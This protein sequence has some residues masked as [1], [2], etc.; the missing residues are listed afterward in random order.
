MKKVGSAQMGGG[1]V[2]ASSAR[3]AIADDL[4]VLTNGYSG[5]YVRIRPPFY[6][7]D[8]FMAISQI[9]VY[10]VIGLN[11]ATNASVYATSSID[12]T[13]PAI[14][15]VDGTTT[16]RDVPNVW[17][18]ATPNRQRE[19]IELD[20][21]STINIFAIRI[22]GVNT[23]PFGNPKCHERMD[24]MRIEIKPDGDPD[25]EQ[26]ALDTYETQVLDSQAAIAHAFI[27]K[28][29]DNA[30]PVPQVKITQQAQPEFG[31]DPTNGCFMLPTSDS[32][33]TVV[34][35]QYLGRYIR[36]RPSLTNGDGFI[37]LSQVIVYDALG[38]NI[39]MG[40]NTYATSSI[41]GTK[42]SSIV[43]D[44]STDLRSVP[45]IWHSNSRNRDTEFFEID[46]GSNQTVFAVRIIGR[47]GCPIP[48]MCENRMLGLRLEIKDTTTVEAMNAYESKP[49]KVVDLGAD[50]QANTVQVESVSSHSS[51]VR[52]TPASLLGL[53]FIKTWNKGVSKYEYRDRGGGT[54]IPRKTPFAA[55]VT[56]VQIL[57]DPTI[58]APWYKYYDTI[59]RVYYYYN[60][61]TGET[62]WSHPYPPRLPVTGETIY[63]DD[64]LPKGWFKYLDSALKTYF[65]YN[66][67]GE[68]T[69]DHPNPPPFPD[70]LEPVS[71]KY[72]P[73]YEMYRDPKTNGIF[74]YNTLT[75]ETFWI[76]PIGLKV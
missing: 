17:H 45:D 54:A 75:T 10:D 1:T 72:E 60:K 8:G 33:Q 42:P 9:I 47:K 46:L 58:T 20:L 44:G 51:S 2:N 3:S 39:S 24:N 18:S 16:I 4:T 13:R 50:Q 15:V 6:S 25:I 48:N 41:S 12:G 34:V 32:D 61:T 76:L 22:L 37:N 65:Y 35:N 7:G 49:H 36:L 31:N 73:L 14:C 55:L 57:T 71:R 19:Y 59:Y 63:A 27:V 68:R 74:Y 30:P 40:K 67:S 70:N 43:V 29:L 56:D 28:S 26:D 52:L 64:G 5:R 38:Q 11:V 23:C 66:P 69:W 21:G 62:S 53:P